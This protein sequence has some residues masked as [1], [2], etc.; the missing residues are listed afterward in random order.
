MVLVVLGCLAVLLANLAVWAKTFA[1]DEDSFVEA[2]APLADDEEVID[3]IALELTGRIMS[4]QP[5]ADPA[6]R[7]LV[8]S[9]VHEVLSSSTFT[10]IWTEALRVAHTQMVRAV[11]ERDG[12][13]LDLDDVLSRVDSVIER[14]GRD[15]LS[16]STIERIDDIVVQT[17]DRLDLALHIVDLVE[18]A[19][20][21]LPFAAVGLIGA[22]VVLAPNRRRRLAQAGLGVA[23]AMVVT[24]V[25]VWL[26]RIDVLR[27]V[28]GGPYRRAAEDVWEGVTRSLLEQTTWLFAAGLLVA[29]VAWAAGRL[30]R[31]HSPP[32]P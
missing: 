20:V 12:V 11:A 26:L 23:V 3:G 19:A 1:Y 5:G 10:T 27:R 6:L 18:R 15:I 28:D 16:G 2:L 25:L 14:R 7:D 4:V 30:T 9:T 13:A 21:V 17:E 24:V 22:A 8:G 32:L 31:P 29:A